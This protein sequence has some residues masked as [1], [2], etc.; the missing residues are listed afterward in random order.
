MIFK[1]LTLVALLLILF[2]SC[3]LHNKEP[4]PQQKELR[5]LYETL[6]S[7]S[8]TGKSFGF[9]HAREL[10]STVE[11]YLNLSRT[12]EVAGIVATM[13]VERIYSTLPLRS[14]C[15][16]VE[17]DAVHGLESEI[18]SAIRLRE[19]R[20]G[21]S[22]QWKLAAIDLDVPQLG[23]PHVGQDQNCDLGLEIAMVYFQFLPISS[24]GFAQDDY[25]RYGIAKDGTGGK[26]G[27]YAGAGDKGLDA[28]EKIE[29]ALSCIEISCGYYANVRTQNLWRVGFKDLLF[30]DTTFDSN[31]SY[32]ECFDPQE[33]AKYKSG[34][35]ELELQLKAPQEVVISRDIEADMVQLVDFHDIAH[36]YRE[37]IF[38]ECKSRPPW[39]DLTP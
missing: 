29:D 8:T 10:L 22:T 37:I 23:L 28:A 31:P 26:C 38:G 19:K 18:Q 27:P 21:V 34:A 33:M 6:K 14:G 25:W 32:D 17:A 2:A 20:V 30:F 16:Q 1:R 11:E 9:R 3:S 13:Q 12:A 4:F 24:C 36:Y 7:G 5:R 35:E 15:R 39:A